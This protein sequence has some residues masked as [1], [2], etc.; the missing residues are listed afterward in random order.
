MR[1]WIVML[2]VLVPTASVAAQSAPDDAPGPSEVVLAFSPAVP[3]TPTT[4]SLR[5]VY[6]S[7]SGPDAKPPAL[8]SLRVQAPIGTRFDLAGT[9]A[10]TATDVELRLLGPAACP[11]GSQVATGSLTAVTGIG[12]PIDPVPAALAVYNTGVGVVSTVSPL[13]LPV[14]V[15]I[16]RVTIGDDQLEAHPPPVPGGPPDFR[17]A[18]RTIEFTFPAATGFVTT[19]PTCP[20]DGRWEYGTTIEFADGTAQT[21]VGSIQCGSAAT[22]VPLAASSAEADPAAPTSPAPT[23]RAALVSL[24]ATGPPPS[25]ILPAAATAAVLV[26]LRIRRAMRSP[27]TRAPSPP[28]A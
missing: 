4:F 10:C 1:P 2:A 25:P 24:P 28:S 16:D 27:A 17:T 20:D 13:G 22:D 18:V 8:T 21:A 19:P 5:A 12:S 23:P 3:G 26:A 9:P 15:A 14:V 7:P 6:R 11:A